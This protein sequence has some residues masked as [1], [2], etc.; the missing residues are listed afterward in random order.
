MQYT[1]IRLFFLLTFASEASAW[2]RVARGNAELKVGAQ[3]TAFSSGNG[4]P[5]LFALNAFV[6][7]VMLVLTYPKLK[8]VFSIVLNQRALFFIY[9]YSLLSVFWSENAGNSFRTGVYLV[10]GLIQFVYI[11][12]FLEAEEQIVT[13]G[14]IVTF[15]AVLSLIG[16]IMLTPAGDFAPGWTGI[17][18]SKNYL[19]NIMA[20][21]MLAILLERG[22][23]TLVRAAKFSFCGALLVLSQS[24]TSIVCA[25]VCAFIILYFKMTRRQKLLL[26]GTTASAMLLIAFVLPNFLTLLLGATGKNTTLTGRDVIWAFAFKY[27]ALKPFFGY[28]YYGFWISQN[29]AALEYLGWNPNQ[30]HNG[31]IDLTLNEGLVGLGI[32]LSVFYVSLRRS[33]RQISSGDPTGAGQWSLIML[34]YLLVHNVSEADFYQRPAWALF[35]VAYIASAKADLPRRYEP[36][37]ELAHDQDA[38]T[39][40]PLQPVLV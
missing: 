23:W 4:D 31:F 2:V 33:L 6:V 34:V 7:F 16:E 21:G 25:V 1:L 38:L 15:L 32:L 27:I 14:Q 10:F 5:V 17:F 13:L 18:P 26:V 29:D 36:Q 40:S 11:G 35:L 19:G 37:I 24:F 3:A 30:A 39:S 8:T 12:W 22:R 28:G 20:L 9:A